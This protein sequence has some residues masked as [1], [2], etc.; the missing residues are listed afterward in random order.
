MARATGDADLL[1]TVNALAC[2]C[3]CFAGEFTKALEHAD[4]VSDLYEPEKHGH[5]ADILNRD[6]KTGAST[7]ASIGNWILG[8]P[9]R[10]S[11]LGDEK[12]AHARRRGYPF[13]LGYALSMGAQEFDHRYKHAALRKRAEEC[14]RLG[15]ENNLP[16]LWK[17]LGSNRIR[18][19][20]YPGRQP[21]RRDCP[22]QGGH[23]GF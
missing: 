20:I 7:F 6:P 15:R 4:K 13:D 2:S 17:M 16:L 21:C 12:D 19:G 10:A 9:D 18:P 14:E 11:R 5:L 8:Y 1:I 23:R 3:Y 22:P